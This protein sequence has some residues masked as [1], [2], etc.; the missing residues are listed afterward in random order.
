MYDEDERTV[1]R[2]VRPEQQFYPPIGGLA[3][4]LGI[5]Q[6]FTFCGESVRSL[7]G[8]GCTKDSQRSVVAI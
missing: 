4:F 7:A 8:V 5:P 1:F 2:T 3:F 6:P